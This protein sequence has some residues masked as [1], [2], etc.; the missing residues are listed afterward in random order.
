MNA[1]HISEIEEVDALSITLEGRERPDG[2]V[3]ISSP[4]LPIFA[5][6]GSCEEEALNNAFELLA[7]YL[8]ANYPE[9]VDLKRVRQCQAQ[10]INPICLLT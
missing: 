9:Y 10:R 1:M 7:P 3:F 4:D 2:S 5:A 8:E 6:V